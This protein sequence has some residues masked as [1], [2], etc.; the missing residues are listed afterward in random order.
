MPQ[1]PQLVLQFYTSPKERRKGLTHVMD[2]EEGYALCGYYPKL[3]HTPTTVPGEIN[4]SMVECS[5]CLRKM[6]RM[7]YSE[8]G[9]FIG[10][11]TEEQQ[12]TTQQ[13]KGPR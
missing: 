1:T 6:A 12:H 11:T 5:G 13:P 4:A 9:T 8:K 2:Q 7:F 10:C 3:G